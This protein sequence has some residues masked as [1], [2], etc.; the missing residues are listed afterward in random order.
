MRRSLFGAAAAALGAMLSIGTAGAMPAARDAGPGIAAPVIAAPGIEAPVIEA[1]GGW[2]HHWQRGYGRRDAWRHGYRE[3]KRDGYRKG[4]V[5]GKHGKHGKRAKRWDRGRY[6]DRYDRRHW[7]ERP[8]HWGRG[9]GPPA[10]F[11]PHPKY[12][13]PRHHGGKVIIRDG[14]VL[15]PRGRW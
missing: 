13:P 9:Y 15:S 2:R 8:R 14:V 7:H 1:G 12:G 3:G 5:H 10:S 11:G 4:W 6:V